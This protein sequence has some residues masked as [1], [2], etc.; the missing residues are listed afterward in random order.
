MVVPA[1][2]L[3]PI[4]SSTQSLSLAHVG[5]SAPGNSVVLPHMRCTDD[6]GVEFATPLPPVDIIGATSVLVVEST[7]TVEG[8]G[9]LPGLRSDGALNR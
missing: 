6:L 5:Y 2:A 9:H 4:V 8:Y 1:P 7:S 3:D